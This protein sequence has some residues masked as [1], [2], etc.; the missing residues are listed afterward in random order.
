MKNTVLI[1]GHG[2][3]A[4][5]MINGLPEYLHHY[6]IDFWE[7]FDRY[8]KDKLLIVHFG[9]G[10]EL[11]GIIEFC[12]NTKSPLI[13]G[14][15]G[16]IQ[17][18]ENYDFTFIDAPNLNILM[19]KFMYMLKKCGQLYTN[20]RVSLIESHQQSKKSTPGTAIEIAGSLGVDSSEIKSIRNPA[21]Q[22][23]IYGIPGEYL[24][25][26]AFH[27]ICIEDEGTL[28]NLRTLVKGHESYIH[29]L[30][31]IIKITDKLQN[32]YYHVI[33]LIELDLI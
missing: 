5:N 32:R 21:D 15:T 1:A 20:Y 31:E 26:H 23:N 22:E 11:P 14:A 33:E 27:E 16:M 8:E 29:G 6:Q 24:D 9:S 13:Q 17:E 25:L 4:I 28:I 7:N 3:L 2:K 30:S 19:L 18:K 10:R 12:K